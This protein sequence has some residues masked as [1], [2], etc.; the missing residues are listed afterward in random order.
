MILALV[1]GLAASLTQRLEAVRLRIQA[2]AQ[3]TVAERAAREADA[4][5]PPP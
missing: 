5:A 2:E 4:N 3:R 1:A